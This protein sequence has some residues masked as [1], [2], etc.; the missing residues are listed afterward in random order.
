MLSLATKMLSE[1]Y[2]RNGKRKGEELKAQLLR[3][4]VPVRGAYTG[5]ALGLNSCTAHEEDNQKASGYGAEAG[6]TRK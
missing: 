6:S 1:A 2:Q 4:I 3:K 5:E